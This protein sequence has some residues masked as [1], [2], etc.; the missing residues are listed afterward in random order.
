MPIQR[1]DPF[2]F[3][4]VFWAGSTYLSIKFS[5]ELGRFRNTQTDAERPRVH[6]R[7]TYHSLFFSFL[8]SPNLALLCLAKLFVGT[9][10]PPLSQ[11]RPT[12]LFSPRCRR[13]PPP[14]LARISPP[15]SCPAPQ[16]SKWGGATA[17]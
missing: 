8:F 6:P 4:C 15:P 17:P 12:L 11:L 3:L 14:C 1:G 2:R 16:V 13:P 5:L 10:S 9:V 7:P